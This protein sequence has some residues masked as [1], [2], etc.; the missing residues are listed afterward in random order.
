MLTG[1]GKPYPTS[2]V[3]ETGLTDGRLIDYN[4]WFGPRG[5][6]SERGIFS[7]GWNTD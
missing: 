6:G 5:S 1:V 3:R 2:Y 4:G 7:H